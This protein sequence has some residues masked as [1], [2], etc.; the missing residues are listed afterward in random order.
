MLLDYKISL[1]IN[2]L[3]VEIISNVQLVSKCPELL[4]GTLS[5]NK[6]ASLSKTTLN[7]LILFVL[8]SFLEN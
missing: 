7:L 5:F 8:M 1:H 4:Q 2:I 3:L 6:V